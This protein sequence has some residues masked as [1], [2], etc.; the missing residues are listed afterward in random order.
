MEICGYGGAV[1]GGTCFRTWENTFVG[2]K[3]GSLLIDG[4]EWQLILE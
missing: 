4:G 3:A 1:G 2:G